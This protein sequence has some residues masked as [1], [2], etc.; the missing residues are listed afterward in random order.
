MLDQETINQLIETAENVMKNAHVPLSSFPVGAAVLTASGNIYAGC[1]TESIIPGLGVCAERSAVDH[2][3]IHGEKDFVAVLVT[4]RLKDRLYPCG[5]CRQYLYEFSQQS[6]R[7]IQVL[8]LTDGKNASSVL[9]SR[10]MPSGFGPSD[11]AA[12]RENGAADC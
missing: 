12:E 5:A 10:L 8:T 9:L 7:D 6:G 2:A 1:N 4:S 3:L 11:L